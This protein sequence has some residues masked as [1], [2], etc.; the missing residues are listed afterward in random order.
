MCVYL[1]V[2]V[3]LSVFLC[4][5]VCVFSLD[6][7]RAHCVCVMCLSLCDYFFLSFLV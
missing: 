3:C 4:V 5:S 2:S 7:F 6:V 1:S